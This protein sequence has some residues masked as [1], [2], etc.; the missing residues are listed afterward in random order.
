MNPSFAAMNK[1]F[2]QSM[3]NLFLGM[4]KTPKSEEK[5]TSVEVNLNKRIGFDDYH[6]NAELDM[7]SFKHQVKADVELLT[8]EQRHELHTAYIDE[9]IA[10]NRA[11]RPM[12][13]HGSV[14]PR[15]DMVEAAEEH[16]AELEAHKPL[17]DRINAAAATAET[18]I[19]D[20]DAHFDNEAKLLKAKYE[21]QL[22]SLHRG[23]LARKSAIHT[24]ERINVELQD[25]EYNHGVKLKLEATGNYPPKPKWWQQG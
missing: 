17:I 18:K 10:K 4:S 11:L 14:Y 1:A 9:R 16:Q 6:E 19:A 3:N 15:S 5:E 24:G 13:D 22:M 12:V 8:A 23:E 7:L 21:K 20:T 2:L 25:A